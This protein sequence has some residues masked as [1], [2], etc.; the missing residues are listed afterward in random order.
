[1]IR[2]IIKRL[3]LASLIKSL[4]P[5]LLIG[6]F[7]ALILYIL[8]L[9]LS[10]ASGIDP[11]LVLRDP[12]QACDFPTAVGMISNLGILMWCSATAICLFSSISGLIIHRKSRQ[13]ICLGG[14]FSAV[15]C[16]DDLFL[17]HDRHVGEDFIHFMYAFLAIFLI[18]RFYKLILGYEP[19]A[20]L[21][22]TIF[23]G[24]SIFIDTV[25]DDVFIGYLTTQFYEEGFKFIGIACWL[26]FWSKSSIIALRKIPE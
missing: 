20:F 12:V 4:V 23:L 25:Q 22:S 7:P 18:F 14:C 21:L 9:Y 6:I 8:V 2:T 24:L 16:L 26:F 5:I 3:E 17:L 13:L 11:I 19:M 1:M 15:L 10:A